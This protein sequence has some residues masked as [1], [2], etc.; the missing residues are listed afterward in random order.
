MVMEMMESLEP[1]QVGDAPEEVAAV[2]LMVV[3]EGEIVVP[4]YRPKTRKAAPRP[5]AR[6]RATPR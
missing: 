2:V 3:H 6:A 1:S 4:A 5:E